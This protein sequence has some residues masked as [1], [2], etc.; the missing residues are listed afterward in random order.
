MERLVSKT[1][2]K[3]LGLDPPPSKKR[4]REDI[5]AANR[6]YDAERRHRK[7]QESWTRDFRWVIHDGSKMYCRICRSVY[8]KLAV[9]AKIPLGIPE[10][11]RKY[12]AGPLVTGCSNMKKIVLS[13]HD[14][15]D[16]HKEARLVIQQR[17]AAPGES[18][19]E[20][21]VQKINQE[22]FERLS[23]I[24]RN[25]HAIAFHSRPF[26]DLVWMCSLD[27][28]KGVNIGRTYRNDKQCK[29]F[30]SAIAAV[31]RRILESELKGAKFIS[32][33]SD[34]SVD[35]AT[36]ENE[37]IYAKYAIKGKAKTVFLSIQAVPRANAQ[38]IYKALMNSLVFETLPQSEIKKKIVGFGSDGAS[39]NTGAVSGVIALLLDNISSEIVLVKCLA[40]RLELAFKDSV[41]GISLYTKVNTLL[42]ELFRFYHKSSLQ[43]ENLKETFRAL[44]LPT[45]LPHRVGG[46]RWV[47][48]VRGALDQLWNG[49]PAFVHHLHQ[50]QIY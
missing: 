45:S 24:F 22:A 19:A 16:G 41:K 27:E 6:V 31:E 23:N 4:T 38:G 5:A 1:M 49:Y 11:F 35:V 21:A 26:R 9:N 37:I 8:G 18:K 17:N 46:T 20:R 47:S 12:A 10:R 33:M 40:H 30:I 14:V 44:A 48:H 7:F 25:A 39:M 32:L 3:F 50:V 13:G 15:S 29:T 28:K 34:G 42:T 2:F 43:T 36:I